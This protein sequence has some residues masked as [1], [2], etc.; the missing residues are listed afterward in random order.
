LGTF[1]FA[2]VLHDARRWVFFNSFIR[3]M[4]AD[5]SGVI[6]VIV[7]T[8][9]QFLPKF[10][11]ISIPHLEVAAGFRPTSGRPWLV[12]FL[13][14]P[15]WAIFAAIFPGIILT[16]LLFFDHN[17]SSLLS[18]KQNFN[19]K[20]GSAFNWDFFV[21]GLMILICAILGI[22]VTHGLIPQAPL[23]VRSLAKIREVRQEHKV[24]EIWVSVIENRVSNLGQ[25]LLI[26]ITLSAP[27]V[28]VLG[29]IPHATLSGLFL[30]MGFISFQ[31]NQFADR[32]K[33]FLTDK[34]RIKIASPY[35]ETVS[36][37]Y[38]ALFTL[39]QIVLLGVTYGVTWTQAAISF[40]IF[41]VLM[42]PVR[43]F[44]LPRIFPL[45]A[46]KDLDC[47]EEEGEKEVDLFD[48]KIEDLQGVNS[49]ANTISGTPGTSSPCNESVP[50][51]EIEEIEEREEREERDQEMFQI[52]SPDVFNN[53]SN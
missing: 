51:T 10:N 46:L 15:I 16:M 6:A 21:L 12:Q 48:P 49:G 44:V 34:T 47:E 11:E 39:I 35:I 36:L 5:S 45:V 37:K 26:G 7:F 33:Y 29:N 24:K 4:I 50:Q 52:R 43:T 22:P 42:V 18:Q 30:F 19:L 25:A 31:G 3:G 13:E 38:I 14:V 1:F 28:F 8:A 2:L 27:F 23:H 40:P 32:V 9:L 53:Q 17:V 41:I 20:K